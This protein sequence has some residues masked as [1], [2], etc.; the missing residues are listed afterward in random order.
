MLARVSKRTATAG[1]AEV[2]STPPPTPLSSGSF[3]QTPTVHRAYSDSTLAAAGTS[4]ITAGAMSEAGYTINVLQVLTSAAAGVGHVF[5]AVARSSQA[6]LLA[7]LQPGMW[8][9]GS[10][11]HLVQSGVA[12]AVWLV[13]WL[14]WWAALPLR[15]AWWAVL[16]PARVGLGAWRGMLWLAGS[17]WGARGG[18]PEPSSPATHEL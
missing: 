9:S 11:L 2:P 7:A 8:L 1:A 18:S 13:S 12:T 5:A 16:L 14:L 10:L 3:S 17:M 15:L 4:A 6:V